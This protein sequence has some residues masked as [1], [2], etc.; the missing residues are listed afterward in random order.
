MPLPSQ[1][2]R[3]TLPRQR[4]PAARAPVRAAAATTTA[5]LDVA[6][7]SLPHSRTQLTVTVPPARVATAYKAALAQARDTISIPGF[8]KGAK[9]CLR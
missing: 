2:K 3:T 8:R 9:V 5:D 1:T 7:A 4:R 6:T